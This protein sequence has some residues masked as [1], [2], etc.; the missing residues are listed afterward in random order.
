VGKGWVKV[1]VVLLGWGVV[2]GRDWEMGRVR[3]WVLGQEKRM[4]RVAL[5]WP[6]PEVE[7]VRGWG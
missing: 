4:V 3:G 6:Q 2:R 7:R 5:G 1:G